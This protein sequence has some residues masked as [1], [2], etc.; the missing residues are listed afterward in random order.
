[1]VADES[2][3]RQMGDEQRSKPGAAIMDAKKKKKKAW[4]LRP[5]REVNR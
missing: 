1:M 3:K 2:K 4:V 5:S